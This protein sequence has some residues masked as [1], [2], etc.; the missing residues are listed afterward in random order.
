[1]KKDT[2]NKLKLLLG[3]TE[4]ETDSDALLYLILDNTRMQLLFKLGVSGQITDVPDELSYI[5]L[6]VAV[7][8]FNRLKNEGM[9]SYTQ[10]GESMTFNTN[11][12]DEFQD[13]IDEWKKQNNSSVLKA[14][15]P[16]RKSGW[17]G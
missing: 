16:Y 2:L 13:D 7:K 3:I 8:R 10:E 12:F 6:E 11:D 5:Q 9:S 4:E 17:F 15:D 1:M 14:I